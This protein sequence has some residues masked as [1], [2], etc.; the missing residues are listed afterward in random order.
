MR[1]SGKHKKLVLL[2]LSVPLLLGV[3]RWMQLHT[4][5]RGLPEILTALAAPD[6]EFVGFLQANPE[7]AQNSMPA[8]YRLRRDSATWK[9][10]H[11]RTTGDQAQA[12]IRSSTG[13]TACLTLHRSRG[14]LPIPSVWRYI[15]GATLSQ[16]ADSALEVTRS[17]GIVIGYWK[18]G[19]EEIE[20]RG[21]EDL[22]TKQAMG[23]GSRFGV[24]ADH[25]LLPMSVARLAETRFVALETTVA[26]ILRL[27]D[28]PVYA[29]DWTLDTFTFGP[30]RDSNWP[31]VPFE[32]STTEPFPA[33]R[34]EFVEASIAMLHS[35]KRPKVPQG[36]WPSSPSTAIV[37]MALE[38]M[39][40]QP[41]HKIVE[42]H[43][44]QP[45][46]MPDASFEGRAVTPYRTVQTAEWSTY[47]YRVS[48]KQTTPAFVP[49]KAERTYS[50]TMLHQNPVGF[51]VRDLLALGRFRLE[52]TKGTSSFLSPDTLKRTEVRW[53]PDVPNRVWQLGWY[54]G[55]KGDSPVW[56]MEL[57]EPGIAV[58]VIAFP[59]QNAVVA[60]AANFQLG[61]S[62]YMGGIIARIAERFCDVE[63]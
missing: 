46:Q 55:G 12:V 60:V 20:A 59:K 43:V 6:P 54:R 35:S 45:L 22:K 31:Y 30:Q 29:K 41:S 15:R 56:S 17:P 62:E 37:L 47:P 33:T 24:R 27:D 51:S 3:G 4:P 48:P 11:M 7:I 44:F 16:M 34:K 2:G 19:R 18:D 57:M 8:L 14:R 42:E 63:Y 50:S 49:L 39:L 40:G 1:L 36:K 28:F 61:S 26:P 25:F 38:A 58:A 13:Q 52:A 53:N 32:P 5:P 10:S 23:P 9:F 21:V